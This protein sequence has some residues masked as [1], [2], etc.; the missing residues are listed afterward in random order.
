MVVWVLRIFCLEQISSIEMLLGFGFFYFF[1]SCF[2]SSS[3]PC[4]RFFTPQIYRKSSIWLGL[5]KLLPQVLE[6][7]QWVIGNGSQI[8]FW[9]D[10]WMGDSLMHLLG[11]CPSFH[12]KVADFIN[13]CRWDLLVNFLR[14]FPHLAASIEAIVLPIDPRADHLIWIGAMSGILSAKEA[15]LWLLSHNAPVPWSTVI[16]DKALQPRK[17][18]V[19][20]KALQSRLFTDE[21]LQKHAF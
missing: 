17:S 18:L 16:W 4:E 1:G 21:F 8:D 19:V 11:I 14:A 13:N 15:Y 5:K 3:F 7:S 10:N 9:T 2:Y 12:A 6:N 20:W